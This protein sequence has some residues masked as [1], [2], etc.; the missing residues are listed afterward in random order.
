MLTLN[1][2]LSECPFYRVSPGPVEAYVNPFKVAVQTNRL[3][4]LSVTQYPL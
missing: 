3:L 4:H 2:A 1:S